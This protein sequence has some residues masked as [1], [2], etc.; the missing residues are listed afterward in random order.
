MISVRWL[1]WWFFNGHLMRMR[2]FVSTTG[3]ARW[4]N[5][6]CVFCGKCPHEFNTPGAKGPEHG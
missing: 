5:W 6:Q 2:K 4:E 3:K 1:G